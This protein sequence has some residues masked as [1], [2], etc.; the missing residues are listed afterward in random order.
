MAG[1]RLLDAKFESMVP[2]PDMLLL[3]TIF[4]PAAAEAE[5]AT[6]VGDAANKKLATAAP[7]LFVPPDA[8]V[9]KKSYNFAWATMI[10]NWITALFNASPILSP[11]N[12]D[13]ANAMDVWD[14]N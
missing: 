4:E 1:M 9:I 5:G 2:N 12:A 13:V 14:A 8:E 7:T 6:C 10:V 3:M 11:D